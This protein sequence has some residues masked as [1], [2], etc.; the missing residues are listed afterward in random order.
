MRRGHFATR[1]KRTCRPRKPPRKALATFGRGW[2]IDA[3][4]KLAVSWYVG[5]RDSE[6]AMM[7]MDDLAKRLAN[8]VQ[9]T[10]DGHKAYLEA[11]K[12]RS[13]RH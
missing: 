13:A 3:E 2:G 6:A 4:S 8:R 11:S 12:A 5:G 9:L 1:S 7:F 10:S